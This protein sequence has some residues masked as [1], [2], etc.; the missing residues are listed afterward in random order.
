[1]IMTVIQ[2]VSSHVNESEIFSLKL[3]FLYTFVTFFLESLHGVTDGVEL[4]GGHM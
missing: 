1:M 3:F 2:I 4:V